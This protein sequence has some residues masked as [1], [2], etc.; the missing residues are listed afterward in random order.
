MNKKII[1]LA[2]VVFLAV[3]L[4][5]HSVPNADGDS[6]FAWSF[7][8]AAKG[9]TVDVFRGFVYPLILKVFNFLWDDWVMSG[10]MISA[11]A[12]SGSLIVLYLIAGWPGA[13]LLLV[14]PVFWFTGYSLTTDAL[15][16]C[17]MCWAYYFGYEYTVIRQWREAKTRIEGYVNDNKYVV[18]GLLLSGLL[19]GLAYCTRYPMIVL[20]ALG[21]FI[22][23]KKMYLFFLPVFILIGL[24]TVLNLMHNTGIVGA[25]IGMN[26]MD[27]GQGF[28]LGALKNLVTFP[29][30]FSI[31]TW[32]LF[33]CLLV[34]AF[35]ELITR[36]R[37]ELVII[38]L[39][40][41]LAVSF[42]FYSPR[43]LLPV[44][45]P[46]CVGGSLFIRRIWKC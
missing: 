6:D 14:S 10:R 46:A 9:E 39:G 13:I 7:V 35:Y 4:I 41:I 16:F 17:L 31:D 38:G 32:P 44:M 37:W 11:L 26:V 28:S 43:F 8:P 20:L 15:A 25:N 21:L 30:Q 22:P 24:Q 1:I 27:K 33:A 34:L 12:M 19:S 23:W 45:L 40:M 3:M 36:K 18:L 29:L 42:T 2:F 5:P